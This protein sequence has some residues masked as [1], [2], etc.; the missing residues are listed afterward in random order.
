MSDNALAPSRQ[1][2]LTDDGNQLTSPRFTAN[3]N[4]D[5]TR[6]RRE[7]VELARAG[8]EWLPEGYNVV[9]TSGDRPKPRL[10][11]SRHKGGGAID[12]QIIGPNNELIPNEGPAGGGP[13]YRQLAHGMYNEALRRDP[14]LAAQLGWGGE[15][16]SVPSTR[17]RP[18]S[19]L[20]DY[21]HFDLAGRRG[22]WRQEGWAQPAAPGAGPTTQLAAAAPAAPPVPPAPAVPPGT[23]IPPMPVIPNLAGDPRSWP[24]ITNVP[25]SLEGPV[26]LAPPPQQT[27]AATAPRARVQP[28]VQTGAPLLTPQAEAPPTPF[29]QAP[30]EGFGTG[31]RPPPGRIQPTEPTPPSYAVPKEGLP[32]EPPNQLLSGLSTSPQ[33]QTLAPSQHMPSY[34]PDANLAPNLFSGGAVP[35]AVAQR[36]EEDRQAGGPTDLQRPPAQGGGA[37]GPSGQGDAQYKRPEEMTTGD[38]IRL[39]AGMARGAIRGVPVSYDP[40]AAGK[41]KADTSFPKSALDYSPIGKLTG[42]PP[43]AIG[44]KV[45]GI[46]TRQAT[47]A[48]AAEPALYRLLGVGRGGIRGGGGGGYS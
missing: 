46:P 23:A 18:G 34:Q 44:D 30:G 3:P 39:A 48:A 17:T 29:A 4:V 5:L 24:P 33:P 41:F 32:D 14:E 19:G 15:F 42:G 26:P 8:A 36:R 10:K 31:L 47:A 38:I 2:R 43:G 13:L 12:V 16:E 7:L 9:V 27:A 35:G 22:Q 11:G 1:T 40:F 25:P 28:L 20:A 6:V 45:P 21:M 37:G